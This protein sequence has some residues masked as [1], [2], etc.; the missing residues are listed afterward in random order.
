M[1]I[2]TPIFLFL[3]F[4]IF[5][6]SVLIFWRTSQSMTSHA[7]QIKETTNL[8][9]N[10]DPIQNFLALK[11]CNKSWTHGYHLFPF[12][13]YLGNLLSV[14]FP[15]CMFKGLL[16]HIWSHHINGE[17]RITSISL[18]VKLLWC[19][20]M[21]FLV[22][23]LTIVEMEKIFFLYIISFCIKKENY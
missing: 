1:Q 4:F 7:E 12:Y 15:F 13:F 18:N 5:A 21:M 14:L 9:Q 3:F 8:V 6:F 23:F 11:L 10:L 22:A 19:H 2:R 16:L 20:E 17:E